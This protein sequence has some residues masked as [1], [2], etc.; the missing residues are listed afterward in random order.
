MKLNERQQN[1]RT[2][3]CLHAIPCSPQASPRITILPCIPN[4]PT[5]NTRKLERTCIFETT[6]LRLHQSALL[7]TI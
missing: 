3:V 7:S 5:P 1:Y 4:F 2:A 6:F